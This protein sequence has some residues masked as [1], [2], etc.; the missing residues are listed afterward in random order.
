MFKYELWK[1]SENI[2]TWITKSVHLKTFTTAKDSNENS[3][4]FPDLVENVLKQ[5]FFCKSS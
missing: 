1:T 2:L 5:Y 4:Y 3:I